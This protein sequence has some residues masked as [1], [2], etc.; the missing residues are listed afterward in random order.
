MEVSLGS[1]VMSK[2]GRDKSNCFIVVAQ[3]NDYVYICDGDLR[4]I[5]KPKKKKKKHLSVTSTVCNS[6]GEKIVAN[7]KVTN[8]ELRRALAEFRDITEAN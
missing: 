5:D 7:N 8:A 2:A 1:I 4:K 3:E 6:I